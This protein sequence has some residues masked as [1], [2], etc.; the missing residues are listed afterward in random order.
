MSKLQ[1]ILKS[2][3]S[4]SL[5]IDVAK[6]Q[7][8]AS[9]VHID[10]PLT[11]I[12]I[13]YLQDQTE[14]VVDMI[15]PLLPVAKQSDKYFTIDKGNFF[16]SMMKKR[17]PMTV[18]G[19]IGYTVSSDSYFCDRWSVGH[20]IPDQVRRNADTAMNLDRQGTELLA[21]QGL[22]L[23][24][25]QW[26]TDFFTT[27][28]WGTD[29]TG[30]DSPA[31]SSEVLKWS[32]D[33]SDP[34]EQMEVARIAIKQSTGYMPNTLV[35]SQV[36]WSW[37]K[38]HPAILDRISQSGQSNNAPRMVM[39]QTVAQLFEVDRLL[40]LGAIVNSA[41]EGATDSIAFMAG[42]HA[43]LGY[44]APTP[45]LMTPSAGYT[46]TWTGEPGQEGSPIGQRIKRYREEDIECDI[47]E[48]DVQMDQKQIASDLGY[49]FSGITDALGSSTTTQT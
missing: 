18:A 12:S 8:T 49:F 44:V 30:S 33:G 43:W 47:L 46:F 13:A 17:A 48:I 24:E 1:D 2:Q 7:P 29:V 32:N 9:D 41:I 15:F 37:L 40:V 36:V 27:G 10:Q 45:G 14:F 34:I 39:K 28:V 26:I 5:V 11:N 38:N 31:S 16:R 4:P 6:Y 19:R 21:Q 35:I 25:N 3:W 23:R 42:N 22:L 20:P